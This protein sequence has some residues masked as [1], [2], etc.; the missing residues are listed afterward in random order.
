MFGASFAD[1]LRNAMTSCKI[2]LIR[3][4]LLK[5][6]RRFSAILTEETPFNSAGVATVVSAM[7]LFHQ[8]AAHR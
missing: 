3:R 2:A 7:S 8:V 5:A 4:P 1:A 6:T